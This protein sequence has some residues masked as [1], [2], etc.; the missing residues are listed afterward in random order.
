MHDSTSMN[1]SAAS[2]AT[3]RPRRAWLALLGLVLTLAGPFVY[4]SLLWHPFL[5]STGLPAFILIASG[6]IVAML[7]LRRD[8][9]WRVWLLTGAALA[10]SAFFAVGFFVFAA[11]PPAHVLADGERAPDFSL[12]DAKGNTVSLADVRAG[13]PALLVFYRGHW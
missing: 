12:P 8:R 4:I 2:I 3:I 7:A 9:R 11:L 10:W 1:P 13:G 5:R 6:C